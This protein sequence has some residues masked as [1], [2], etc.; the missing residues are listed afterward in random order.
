MKTYLW[1]LCLIA[2]LLASSIAQQQPTVVPANLQQRV[3]AAANKPD[4]L[5]YS[6]LVV[7]NEVA[8]LR[9]ETDQ[10]L[11]RDEN[12]VQALKTEADQTKTHLIELRDAVCPLFKT[13]QLND[14]DK[15]K[16]ASV[17]PGN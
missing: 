12:V 2:I 10:S 1:V 15:A 7:Q 11:K 13:A 17:C 16:V 9:S 8:T 5:A 3:A 6:I 14:S 4:L